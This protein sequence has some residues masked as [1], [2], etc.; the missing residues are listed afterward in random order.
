MTL[1]LSRRN[2]LRVRRGPLPITEYPTLSSENGYLVEYMAA[3]E[4][5]STG[6]QYIYAGDGPKTTA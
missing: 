2:R 1:V 4:A 6:E 3:F 5:T